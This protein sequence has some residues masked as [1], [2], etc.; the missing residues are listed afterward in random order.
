MKNQTYITE[1]LLN[2]KPNTKNGTL[3]T[4][5]RAEVLY[6]YSTPIA[7]K[8]KVGQRLTILIT[9]HRYSGTTTHHC[10][11]VA[12]L[13]DFFGYIV[14]QPSGERDIASHATA[15]E[16]RDAENL[17]LDNFN[18]EIAKNSSIRAKLL[19]K[20]YDYPEVGHNLKAAVEHTMLSAYESN[21]LTETT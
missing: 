3:S 4:Q 13:A 15:Q 12:D 10:N 8:T 1:W 18:T 11:M 21:L 16:F 20:L 17:L 14:L 9:Q 5:A 19:R 6:S 7:I 2:P